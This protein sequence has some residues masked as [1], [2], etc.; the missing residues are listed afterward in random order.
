MMLKYGLIHLAIMRRPLP[1]GMN[2]NVYGLFKHEVGGKIMKEFILLRGKTY[3][4]LTDD[5]GEKKKVKGTK[6][7]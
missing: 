4:Y 3:A 2:K 1:I 7:G 5:D 6:K